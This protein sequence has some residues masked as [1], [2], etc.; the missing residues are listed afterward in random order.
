MFDI[1]SSPNVP[2]WMWW[3][4]ATYQR[5]VLSKLSP[6]YAAI[7]PNHTQ[8]II[9]WNTAKR[10]PYTCSVR[11]VGIGCYFVILRVQAASLQRNSR[12]AVR[13]NRYKNIKNT[14]R[15]QLGK[16]SQKVVRT[17]SG[18]EVD[19]AYPRRG[20]VWGWTCLVLSAIARL[21][22]PCQAGFVPLTKPGTFSWQEVRRFSTP[23]H[24]V[25]NCDLVCAL[26]PLSCRTCPRCPWCLCFLSLPIRSHS[27]S[28][29]C[30]ARGAQGSQE[31]ARQCVQKVKVDQR[32][33][34]GLVKDGECIRF[35][36]LILP[37]PTF[38]YPSFW[39]DFKG[40]GQCTLQSVIYA[41][42]I[43]QRPTACV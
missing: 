20:N 16:T 39:F 24:V 38:H 25:H 28:G 30:A 31:T 21:S 5:V 32:F 10:F 23:L 26:S 17:S 34:P 36:G 43:R 37:C 9:P 6:F 8:Y 29:E 22:D 7:E 3:E 15:E 11:T 42:I 12:L 1:K 13:D 35:P 40:L 33:G 19:N 27:V 41:L 18:I 4:T 2:P 14:Q